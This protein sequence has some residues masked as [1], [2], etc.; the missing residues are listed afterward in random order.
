MEC[1][2]LGQFDNWATREVQNIPSTKGEEDNVL[3]GMINHRIDKTKTEQQLVYSM[4]QLHNADL[5]NW[6]LS[7]EQIFKLKHFEKSEI[8]LDDKNDVN[9]SFENVQS[10]LVN[11]EKNQLLYSPRRSRAGDI[12]NIF[13]N[14]GF[15]T[16]RELKINQW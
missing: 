9:R 15:Q 6:V 11:V 1:F 14:V 7:S 2:Y 16:I 4:I 10:I 5:W 13:Y 3:L 8:S 12:T